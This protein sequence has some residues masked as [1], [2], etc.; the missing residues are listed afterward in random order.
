MRYKL[1]FPMP[2]HNVVTHALVLILFFIPSSLGNCRQISG[3]NS[4]RIKEEDSCLV[5]EHCFFW[6]VHDP[7]TETEGA[8]CLWVRDSVGNRIAWSTFVE[9]YVFFPARDDFGGGA[10]ILAG[11]VSICG[12]C[13]SSCYSEYG[14]FLYV[15]DCSN[16]TISEV[17][18]VRC[19]PDGKSNADIG[20]L[21]FAADVSPVM[22][23]VNCTACYGGTDAS[24]IDFWG[25]SGSP[26]CRYFTILK[27]T[28]PFSIYSHR[29]TFYV[30]YGNFVEN[31]HSGGVLY[32]NEQLISLSHCHFKGNSGP[33]FFSNKGGAF[34]VADCHVS[35]LPDGIPYRFT[36]NNFFDGNARTLPLCHL[37]TIYCEKAVDCATF[38]FTASQAFP[39]SRHLRFSSALSLSDPA[40]FVHH[41]PKTLE[42]DRHRF[43][44]RPPP[45][46][47]LGPAG[48]Q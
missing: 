13:G 25:T 39:R 36:S 5:V 22:R 10:A 17:S 18:A 32:S 47:Q 19:A 43:R 41:F 16:C 48:H 21:D 9:C 30:S 6:E 33:I 23:S 1:S 3:E 34:S 14:Q 40:D 15:K 12:C 31:S 29:P 42:S 44:V 35:S 24:A 20:A 28:G 11:E 45:P 37:S 7:L 38:T 8:I 46:H 4:G 27:C 26:N 2:R